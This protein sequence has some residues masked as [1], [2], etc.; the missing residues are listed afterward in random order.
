[1]HNEL[2]REYE[3]AMRQLRATGET[4]LRG[5]V[6]LLVH[7]EGAEGDS[8]YNAAAVVNGLHR[9][10]ALACKRDDAERM[11]TLALQ[12]AVNHALRSNCTGC[13]GW[14]Y[15]GPVPGLRNVI[16]PCSRCNRYDR[17]RMWDAVVADLVKAAP[18]QPGL[19][20]PKCGA[21][22][23][24]DAGRLVLCEN[25]NLW[26]H[27]DTGVALD[28]K[29]CTHPEQTPGPRHTCTTCG[30]EVAAPAPTGTVL[31]SHHGEALHPPA[32][33]P[34][35]RAHHVGDEPACL[36][37]RDTGVQ[38]DGRMNTGPFCHCH[39]GQQAAQVQRQ[40]A[41]Q[42][43]HAPADGRVLWWNAGTTITCGNCGAAIA[44]SQRD[45]YVGE[46][47]RAQDF[48]RPDGTQLQAGDAKA[49]AACGAAFSSIGHDG[50]TTP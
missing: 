46:P 16:E 22:P 31:V 44:I 49:C 12:S 25:C 48:K 11:A 42:Q 2:M 33:V 18:A 34:A 32:L 21:M 38:P 13:K 7:V 50:R 10:L 15:L 35:S 28:P 41:A 8:R 27:A 26:L 19:V 3:A 9:T 40:A 39:A 5:V 43:R 36:D 30:S 24:A 23:L 37:C 6:V 29:D 14:G 45:L 1:M 20:C 17:F 4:K 47:Q